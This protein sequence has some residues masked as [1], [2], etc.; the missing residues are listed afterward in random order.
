MS[1]IITLLMGDRGSSGVQGH[2]QLYSEY[3]SEFPEILSKKQ[4][5]YKHQECATFPYL[6]D[7]PRPSIFVAFL[8]LFREP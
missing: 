7:N 4:N 2:P 3:E 5:K 1:V 6:N 8:A